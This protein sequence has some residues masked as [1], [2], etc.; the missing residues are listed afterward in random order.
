MSKVRKIGNKLYLVKLVDG[1]EVLKELG[2]VEAGDVDT[3][4]DEA[5]TDAGVAGADGAGEGDDAELSDDEK[6]AIDAQA[7]GIASGIMKHLGVT[8]VGAGSE[9][10]KAL[11][12][13]VDRLLD[14][15]YGNDSKLKSIL[16]GKAVD[17]KELTKE[18]KIVGFYHAL[19]T[20]NNA[21]VKAL[22]EGTDADGGYLFPNEFMAELI[23]E[24]P[25]INVMRNEVRVIQMR[26]DKMDVTKLV[27]GPKLSWT[28]EK[29]A[30]STTTATFDTVQLVA[31]KLASILYAS[32]ELIDDSDIFN[33]VQLIIELFSEAIA[34][35]EERV[36]WV[37]NGTTQPQG[38]SVG[39]MSSITGSGGIVA[40]LNRLFY[41]VPARYRAG[42]KFYMSS[43]TAG[44]LHGVVDLDGRPIMT[45]SITDPSTSVIKG[46]PVV[47]SEHVPA[48]EIYFGDLKKAYFFGDRQKMSV[49]I[50]QDTTEAFT[51]GET[52]IRVIHRIAGK[53]V[54]A[55]A[56]RKLTGLV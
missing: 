54:F 11:S 12:S 3:G 27:S 17:S 38:L 35:E 2:D 49:K 18:E 24:L 22:S 14:G 29:T 53:L 39:T 13:K 40:D 30:I 43:E 16:N 5:G 1:K 25:N 37:G 32:D 46:K 19:V 52:A 28:A 31:F 20:G 44:D 34:E 50:S 36:I 47:I 42:A 7:K 4:A 26:R 51:K 9:E 8:K 48:N 55:S 45:S 21:V 41:M 10:M 56:V 33:V 23:K 6:K 15:Q